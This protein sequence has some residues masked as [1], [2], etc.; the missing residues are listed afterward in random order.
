MD[1][2]TKAELDQLLAV[3]R[4][5]SLQILEEMGQDLLALESGRADA[6]AMSRLRRGAHTIKGDSACIALENVTRVA[7]KIEDVFDAVLSGQIVFDRR[8]VDMIFKA[9]DATKISIGG[10]EVI[11]ISTPTANDL[12]EALASIEESGETTGSPNS[13]VD[14]GAEAVERPAER[15]SSS[16]PGPGEPQSKQRSGF[17]RVESDK[18]D[19]LLNLAGEM[20]IARSVMSQLGP[21]LETAFPRN[22]MVDRFS[23]ASNQMGKLIA[24]LQK[25]VLK[26]RMVTIDHVFRRFGRPMREL[27]AQCGKEVRLQVTGGETELDRALVDI[28]YEPLLH[29]L[30][31]AIDHGLETIEDRRNAGKP[32]AGQIVMRAYHE[33]NQVVVEVADDGRGIDPDVVRQKAI[34]VGVVT[35]QDAERMSDEDA[36]ELI[37]AQGVSTARELTRLSGRG[38]GAAAVKAAIEQLRGTVAVKSEAGVGTCFTLRMPLTLAI[39]KALLFSA[40]GQLF[41][42]PLLA[43]SEIARAE[44]SDVVHLDGVENYRLRD[45]FISLVRPGVVL[46]FDR[47]RG[48][49]GAALRSEPKKF[50]VVVLAA[51]DKRYGVVAD[52]LFGEQEL[53]IKPLD[54]SWV[55]NDALAGASVLGDGRVVLIMDAEMVFRKAVKYERARGNYREAYAV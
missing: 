46:S 20:V 28:L 49:S 15:L 47:R 54:S 51:G 41:A 17:V 18:I 27:A 38:V 40:A 9:L 45:R 19:T 53:V 11:D 24:E 6:E 8:S 44:G 3:F 21:E 55:Q 32:E 12:I 39:I 35:K 1:D 4:D 31:N 2:L 5:Q 29:L 37:F 16:L 36:L 13:S 14:S 50:F 26:M 25:S 7:H 34:E 22:E 42:L 10:A 23:G 43:V 52:E 48:G 30:R 33:G